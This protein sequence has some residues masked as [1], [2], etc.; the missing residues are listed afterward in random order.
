MS[1]VT[2]TDAV[3]APSVMVIVQASTAWTRTD[4]PPKGIMAIYVIDAL[5]VLCL[6][7]VTWFVA[8]AIHRLVADR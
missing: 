3:R 6:L 4:R 8:Y 7:L 5:L 2:Y 1:T